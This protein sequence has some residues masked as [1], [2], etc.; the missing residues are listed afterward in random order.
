MR[1]RRGKKNHQRINLPHRKIVRRQKEY[2]NRAEKKAADKRKFPSVVSRESQSKSRRQFRFSSG[3][4]SNS[5]VPPH[6]VAMARVF[7]DLFEAGFYVIGSV[8]FASY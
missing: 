8:F 3:A 5:N 4:S 1:F 6:N 2:D 7:H